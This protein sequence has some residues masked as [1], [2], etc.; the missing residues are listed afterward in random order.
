ML[1]FQAMKLTKDD[2]FCTINLVSDPPLQVT[3]FCSLVVYSVTGDE[4]F[5]GPSC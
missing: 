3:A 2:G 5:P 1:H 4:E